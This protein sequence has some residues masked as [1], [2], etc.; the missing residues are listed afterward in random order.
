MA[1]C[2]DCSCDSASCWDLEIFIYV[3]CSKWDLIPSRSTCGWSSVH[4]IA[5]TM[6][7]H[8]TN[9]VCLLCTV[10]LEVKVMDLDIFIYVLCSKWDLI[11]SRSAC[12]WS[13]VHDIASTMGRHYTN[14]VCLLCTVCFEV[15]V[16]DL[17]IFIH[18]LCSKWD[19]IPSKSFF[20]LVYS[21]NCL[22][23]HLF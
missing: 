16:M 22:S 15:K 2:G 10:C 12:G 19:L 23:G 21:K 3:L 4:D 17:D 18:L 20:G 9:I 7:R 14:I 5:S 13:S 11:L 1:S 6:G 8:Y